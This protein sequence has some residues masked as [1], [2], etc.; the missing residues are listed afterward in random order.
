MGTHARLLLAQL[1]WPTKITNRLAYA[2]STLSWGAF[3]SKKV[4]NHAV[5]AQ[6]FPSDSGDIYDDWPYSEGYV[7]EKSRPGPITTVS[8]WTTRIWNLSMIFGAC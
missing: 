2:I 3:D 7:L 4:S 5:T 8:E 6:D 1:R